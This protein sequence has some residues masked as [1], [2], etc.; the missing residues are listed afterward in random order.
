[1]PKA[2][3]GRQKTRRTLQGRKTGKGKL[4]VKDP[5]VARVSKKQR[6]GAEPRMRAGLG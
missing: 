5:P 1:M 2:V 4:G 6:P 3:K